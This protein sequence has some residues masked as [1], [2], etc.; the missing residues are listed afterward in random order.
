MRKVIGILIVVAG[1]LSSLTGCSPPGVHTHSTDTRFQSDAAGG[2]GGG[3]G[4]GGY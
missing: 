3:G 2:G 4:G 1:C